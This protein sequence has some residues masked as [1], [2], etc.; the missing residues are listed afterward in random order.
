MSIVL[1]NC[2]PSKE[3]IIKSCLAVLCVCV[4]R[5]LIHVYPFRLSICILFPYI[6][7]WSCTLIYLST[8]T[9]ALEI[10]HSTGT[11]TQ[12][13]YVLIANEIL[14]VS[15]SVQRKGELPFP[16]SIAASSPV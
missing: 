9:I 8:S 3:E 14:M 2:P 12:N 1:L 10:T 11:C 16:P 15:Q 5:Y 13:L 7:V 6:A 4:Q